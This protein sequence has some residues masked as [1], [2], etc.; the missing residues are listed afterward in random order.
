MSEMNEILF[1][2]TIEELDGKYRFKIQIKMTGIDTSW[3][4]SDYRYGTYEDA[5]DSADKIMN[6]VCDELYKQ[7]AKP[8]KDTTIQ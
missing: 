5:S 8:L 1:S 2:K 3:N 6:A 4:T 7:G